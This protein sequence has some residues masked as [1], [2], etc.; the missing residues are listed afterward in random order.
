MDTERI[1]AGQLFA[2]RSPGPFQ[3]FLLRLKETEIQQL[4][5]SGPLIILMHGYVISNDKT[6]TKQVGTRTIILQLGDTACLC[7]EVSHFVSFYYSAI[8]WQIMLSLLS[9]KH[10]QESFQ[11]TTRILRQELQQAFFVRSE[12]TINH[13]N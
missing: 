6:I 2:T 1:Y 13:Q 10:R 5:F 9:I 3:Q 4:L 7:G 11:H 12:Y 8:E